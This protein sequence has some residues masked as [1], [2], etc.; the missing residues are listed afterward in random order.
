MFNVDLPEFLFV[1]ILALV[2]I[3]PKDLPNVMRVVGRWVGKARSVAGNFR[4]EFDDMVRQSEMEE[5]ERKWAAENE[6]IMSEHP[7]L[8]P[9]DSKPAIVPEA[10]EKP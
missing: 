7:I 6:R 10:G 1:A 9:A 4:S 2:I 5:L 3:G 8:P